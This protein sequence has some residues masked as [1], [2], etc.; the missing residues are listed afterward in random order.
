LEENVG[1]EETLLEF[2]RKERCEGIAGLMWAPE[3]L[4]RTS[5]TDATVPPKTKAMKTNGS[6][7]N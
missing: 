5:M 3:Y 4:P 7:E 6:N 2:T 1:G